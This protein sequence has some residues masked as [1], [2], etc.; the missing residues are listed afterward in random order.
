LPTIVAIAVARAAALAEVA[1][2]SLTTAYTAPAETTD[3]SR[4]W[5]W[6]SCGW[7]RRRR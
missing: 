7:H 4:N 5:V 3:A 2:A 1:L 6:N